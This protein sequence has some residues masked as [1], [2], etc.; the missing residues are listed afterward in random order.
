VAGGS[1]AA[2]AATASHGSSLRIATAR[3]ASVAQTV[4]SSGTIASSQK[5]AAAF[6]VTGNVKSI[7]V[8]VG[9]T[10]SKG[11][12]LAQLDTTSLRSAVY[13]DETTLATAKQKLEADK[14]G[15]TTTPTGNTGNTAGAD[16]TPSSY[17]TQS[18]DG[19]HTATLTVEM[20]DARTPS[21]GTD[22]AGLI[23][24]ITAAQLPV[25]DG[26]KHIDTTQTAIDTA[27]KKVNKDIVQN[28]TFSNTQQTA[29]AGLDDTAAQSGTDSPSLQPTTSPSP[30]TTPTTSPTPTS[31]PTTQPT[32]SPTPPVSAACTT[33]M[34]NYEGF[35]PTLTTDMSTL[36]GLITTQ[37]RYI[38]SLKTASNALDALIGQLP[39]AAAGSGSSQ[40]KGT[41]QGGSSSGSGQSGK[42]SSGNGSG[43]PNS[44]QSSKSNGSQSPG[45][46]KSSNGSF[47][48]G[49]GKT[50]SG[51]SGRGAQL[52]QG[53]TSGQTATAGPASAAQL[54]ADQ[55][56]I[57]AAQADLVVDQQN[58]TAATLTSPISGTVAAV[59]MT[60]GS[61]PN[62]QTIT[63]IGKGVQ[64][65]SIA[66]PLGEIDLV[67]VGQRATLTAD[68]TAKKLHGTVS[69]VGL[70]SSTTGSST[71]FPVT[72][73][74][75]SDSPALFDGSG[76][77]VTISTASATNVLTVPNSAIHTSANGR[78]TVTVVDGD[79]TTTVPVTIGV[80]GSAV[81]QIKSGLKA[82][83][84]VVL[85]DLS[86]QL[87]S[88]STSN[89]GTTRFP[90]G[91][92]GGA[93]N[94]GAAGRR[95]VG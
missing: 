92:G 81:S 80:T 7:A 90:G 86:Q 73:D 24:Q 79:K 77:D 3:L 64:Q 17:N 82:G 45:S 65:A 5:S 8:K 18:A 53:N 60:V 69:S 11:Q 72:V 85:A 88:S 37:D 47:G 20:A 91:F 78:H 63:I 58:L 75:D 30:S 50:G 27:Q 42:S 59:G 19:N 46:G 93:F 21:G 35:A 38:Q 48:S 57:D 13:T 67:K 83:Q 14:T 1:A 36:S 2:V 70:L 66:V 51:Q 76:A 84:R 31:T 43:R 33:A 26:Q 71:T 61:S 9:S 41:G 40:P 28:T 94:I 95:P 10:V 15:Q 34:A 56:A 54:A 25:I 89:T 49:S 32:G 55:G 22:L 74:L 62:G 6:S 29:C 87:P 23:K 39:T 68:G 52:G 16:A 44:G 12:V 4:E